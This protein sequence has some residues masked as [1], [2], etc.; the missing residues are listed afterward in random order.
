ML[1]IWF[2]AFIELI[3]KGRAGERGFAWMLIEESNLVQFWPSA[4]KAKRSIEI[5]ISTRDLVPVTDFGKL[6]LNWNEG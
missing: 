3:S 5:P 1:G 6:K 2:T 4:A